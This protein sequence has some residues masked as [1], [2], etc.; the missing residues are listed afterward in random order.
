MA[1]IDQV[2]GVAEKL[3]GEKRGLSMSPQKFFTN[4]FYD[5]VPISGVC[6]GISN[7]SVKCKVGSSVSFQTKGIAT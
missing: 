4:I 1:G 6:Q 2:D 7:M 5:I 3:S